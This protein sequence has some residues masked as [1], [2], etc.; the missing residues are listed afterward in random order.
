FR[1]LESAYIE[2]NIPLIESISDSLVNLLQLIPATDTLFLIRSYYLLGASMV[3]TQQEK[4][5]F[6]YFQKTLQLLK[7]HQDDNIK[8][9]V[10]YFLGYTYNKI[11]DH[12]KSISCFSQSLDL[13]KKVYGENSPEL[14][15]VLISMSIAKI[16]LRDYNDAVDII[17]NGLHIATRKGFNP[18]P[19]DLALLYQNKG[20]TL[21]MISEY[22]QAI[23][24][25]LKALDIYEAKN[26]PADDNRL[27]LTNNIATS[28]YYLGETEKSLQ[29]FEKGYKQASCINSMASFYYVLNY[30]RMLGKINMR[31]KGEYVIVET[32]ARLKKIYPENSM[33]YIEMLTNYAG[34]LRN[35]YISLD[36]PLRIY[37]S[38]YD[39]VHNHP[40][41][42]N[43]GN[44]VALG[45]A[46]SLMDNGRT[47]EALDS[48]SSILNR[49]AGLTS[50]GNP[51]VNPDIQLL[52]KD[53]TTWDI[54]RAKYLI[55]HNFYN[56]TNDREVLLSCA[57]TA[58]MMVNVLENIRLNLGEEESKLLL[59]ERYRD[60]YMF[61]IESYNHCYKVTAEKQYLEK[62]FEYSEKSK[63]TSL[64]TY[65]REAKGLKYYVPPD[66]VEME[67]ALVIQI[68]FYDSQIAIER[69]SNNPDRNK[70]ENWTE[71]IMVAQEKRD[72]L[73]EV[74]EKKYPGYYKLKYDT[75]VVSTEI[76]PSLTGE[77]ANYLSY[78]VNDTVLYIIIVNRKLTC[79]KTIT[80]DSSFFG[81][82]SSFRR[83]L[84]EP[85]KEG[86]TRE[87]FI[88]FQSD[89]F[90][91]YSY[92]LEPVREY[93]ISNR[94]VISPDNELSFFPY[95]VM[96]CSDKKDTSL[97]YS[98]LDYVMKKYDICYTYSATLLSEI[99]KTHP[100]LINNSAVFS[101]AYENLAVPESSSVITRMIPELQPLRYARQEAVYVSKVIP[102][103]LFIDN[104]ATEEA[105]RTEAGKFDIVHLAMHTIVDGASSFNSGMIFY[106]P[107]NSDEDLFLRT[108]EIYGIPLSAKMVVLSSCYTGSGKLYAGEG[109]LSLAR[110]FIISGARSVVMSL[111]E[112]DDMTGTEII[113]SYY[114]NLKSGL[115]KSTALKKAR[116]DYINKSDMRLS[117]PYYW[118][119]LIIYGDN[120]PL[121]IHWY[122][123]LLALVILIPG[124]FTIYHYFI[125][126]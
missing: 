32:I 39:Y 113:K 78:I 98:D 26:L 34:Y 84:S 42:V 18:D 100:S 40:W 99:T 97:Y 70:I 54:L 68:G 19:G 7:S 30:A 49:N 44:Q 74:F 114:K 79:I 35:N 125:K 5:S 60:S 1:Q 16:N 126:R 15:P 108:Y 46:L 21:L 50:S 33:E 23:T 89:G 27:N 93:L 105:Y 103:K 104:Q 58:E 119:T 80:I 111:W 92:L 48:I 116:L 52:K 91:L 31:E 120:S 62:V 66:L 13:K 118:S 82:I 47:K 65:T 71:N 43:L 63:A 29:Y 73:R 57:A 8:G 67:Q 96:I 95:E 11:G 122:L 38:C 9:R 124:L 110:A 72:S 12:L 6:E 109:V 51:L 94:L 107:A 69:N 87:S 28:Y 55:L 22:K 86:K 4:R 53:K 81:T 101:P 88:K 2:N 59:G 17:N 25:L 102:G 83:L 24:N 77:K 64:L 75:R 117:H 61:A 41:N 20:I 76:V 45:Y 56:Q 10:L 121:Y 112:I 37:E 36:K 3:V 123:K 115:R 85:V 106:P 90:R 14:L